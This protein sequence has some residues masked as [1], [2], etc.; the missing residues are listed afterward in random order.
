MYITAPLDM[1]ILHAFP[2]FKR[3]ATVFGLLIMCLAFA[4]SS[5][6]KNITHLIITQG[7]MYAIGGGLAY[8]PTILFMEEWFSKRK[9]L[10]F[11]V[12][13]AG[14]G[15]SGVILPIVLQWFLNKYGFRT[16]L[17]AWSVI[18]FVCT[19]PLLYFVKP[20]LPQS[21]TSR[22]RPF[23][24]SF[25]LTTT[26]LIYELGN[27]IEALGFFL[28][29]IYLPTYARSL[30]ADS[31]ASSLTVVAVNLSSVF[32]C[33]I[34][35]SIV[36]KYHSTTCILVSTV[37]S[38]IGVFLIWGFSVSLA[39]LFVFCIFY[40]LFAGSFTSTWPAVIREVQRKKETA[41]PGMVFACLAA[42]RGIGNVASGPLSEALMKG[43]PWHD[44][45]G[46]AYGSGFGTLIVFT[47]VTALA[48][49]LSIFA[50]PLKLV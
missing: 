50:R 34:M 28:P 36:D 3:W 18:L 27:I 48:G 10:A 21:Q 29:G 37:G 49:G 11:G 16:T 6:S 47:G 31:L 40:G 4:L 8:C 24:F 7:V 45:V 13:W 23:D 19:A 5:F 44:A 42:G 12:M 22:I 39:P 46:W 41:D 38:T 15:L 14:T 2:R 30:G 25:L 26:F 17:R 1:A 9:G 43:F 32:G 33:V 20:R 35:G